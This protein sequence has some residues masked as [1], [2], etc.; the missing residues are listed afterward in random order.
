M[1]DEIKDATLRIMADSS[2]SDEYFDSIYESILLLK[3]AVEDLRSYNMTDDEILDE[4]HK[5]GII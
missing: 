2:I 5:N 4:F 1:D 3:E